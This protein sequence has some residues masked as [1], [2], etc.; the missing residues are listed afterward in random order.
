MADKKI[1]ALTGAST[2]LAGTEVLPIVQSST[3]VKVSVANLTAG[4]AVS[5]TSF[6]PTGSTVPANGMYLPATNE[7]GFASDTTVRAAIKSNG[8][9]KWSDNGASG[10]N[11]MTWERLSGTGATNSGRLKLAFNSVNW[12]PA[13][14]PSV[15]YWDG[16]TGGLTISTSSRKYKRNITPVTDA[17]LDKAL[18]LK[19]S[20]YQR[21]EYD[22]WEYGLIAE[23]V[24]EAG[25]DEFVTKAENE[26]SGLNYE[27]MVTLAFGLIQRQQKTI[28]DLTQ[29]V[30]ALQAKVN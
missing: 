21:N 14:L 10:E 30:A 11:A 15:L 3:T 26:I 5:A 19:P 23:E 13:S 7:V 29:A 20:Y 9:M 12:T 8:D 27:K 24:S 22:Y 1:S 4:R 6:A 16:N 2:P 18:L 25:L 17:Q 28:D